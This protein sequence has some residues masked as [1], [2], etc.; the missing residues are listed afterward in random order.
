MAHRKIKER[1]LTLTDAVAVSLA[2]LAHCLVAYL[3]YTL[4]LQSHVVGNLG[5]SV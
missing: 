3:T 1:F 2:E 5:H 4:A